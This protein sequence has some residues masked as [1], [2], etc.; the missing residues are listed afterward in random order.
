MLIINKTEYIYI[1]IFVRIYLSVQCQL[2]RYEQTDELVQEKKIK[3][4]K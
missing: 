1:N 4:M 3:R 2:L